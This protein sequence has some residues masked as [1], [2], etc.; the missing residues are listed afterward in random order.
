MPARA[1]RFLA[2]CLVLL[3]LPLS[4]IVAQ[5]APVYPTTRRDSVVDDYFGTKVADPYRW[6]EDQNSAEVARWVE[7]VRWAAEFGFDFRTW[8]S[9]LCGFVNTPV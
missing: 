3:A 5:H 4:S 7:A 6:L 8:V 2:L 9:F 1:S